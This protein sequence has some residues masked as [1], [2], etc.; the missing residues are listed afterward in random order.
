MER[1]EYDS[2]IHALLNDK[3]SYQTVDKDPMRSLK[4]Q[5]SKAT[6]KLRRQEQETN[7]TLAFLDVLIRHQPNGALSTIVYRKATHTDRILHHESNH[8][9]PLQKSFL[10]A[11]AHAAG[12]CGARLDFTS[13]LFPGRR[14]E[15]LPIQLAFWQR[16]DRAGES[17]VRQSR[18]PA[19]RHRVY[20]GVHGQSPVE[21]EARV[22][23]NDLCAGRK[24]RCLLFLKTTDWLTGSRRNGL[25]FFWG[26]NMSR[27]IV[28]MPLRFI[29]L[30]KKKGEEVEWNAKKLFMDR[31][32]LHHAKVIAAG[33]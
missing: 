11:F 1:S 21:R 7:G 30:P 17:G 16:H 20:A 15:W 4:N 18:F 24:S 23:L 6:E 28:I 27:L 5:L 29:N 8:P 14:E 32:S 12:G 22:V 3:I 19:S 9:M 31:E 33:A 10:L 26:V 13:P 25:P 2:K